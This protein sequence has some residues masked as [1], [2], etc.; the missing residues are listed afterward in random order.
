MYCLASRKAKGDKKCSRRAKMH[1]KHA[2]FVGKRIRRRA[3]PFGEGLLCIHDNRRIG[4]TRFLLRWK[5]LR[6]N[7]KR[8]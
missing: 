8:C 2:R 4:A 7:C 1:H 6:K 3:Y 5:P